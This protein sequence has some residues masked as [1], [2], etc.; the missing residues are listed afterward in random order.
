VDLAWFVTVLFRWMHLLAA[1]TAVGGTFF[2][3]WALLPTVAELPPEDQKIVHS[4]VRA[5]WAIPVHA[6][7]AFLLLSGFYT[8]IFRS[9]PLHKGNGLYHG[10]FGAKFLLALAIFFIATMLVGRSPAAERFRLKRRQWLTVNVWLAIAVVCVS[11]VLRFLPET[12][13]PAEN[14]APAESAQR[15]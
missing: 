13:L 3:R 1:I 2:M 14:T 9:L 6:S 7:I 5:R 8:F 4:G 15:E 11:G 12:S 10:L